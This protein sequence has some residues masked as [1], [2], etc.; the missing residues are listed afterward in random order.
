MKMLN[1][2]ACT[3]NFQF[4]LGLIEIL[5]NGNFHFDIIYGTINTTYCTFNG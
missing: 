4:N 5:F 1:D 2:I 3:L